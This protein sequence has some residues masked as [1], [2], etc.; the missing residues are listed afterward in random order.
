MVWKRSCAHTNH[1]TRVIS[2]A[3]VDEGVAS[4]SGMAVCHSCEQLVVLVFVNYGVADPPLTASGLA[5]QGAAGV[6]LEL[7]GD[8]SQHTPHCQPGPPP[9]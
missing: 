8:D 1:G 5:L 6:K 4:H 9:H 7:D 2:Q 3:M